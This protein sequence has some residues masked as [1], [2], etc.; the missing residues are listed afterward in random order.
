MNADSIKSEAIEW[1]KSIAIAVVLAFLLKTFVFNSTKVVGTSMFP[2]LSENDRVFVNKIVYDISEPQ[3]GDIITLEAPDREDAEYI[4]RI[5]GLAG[6]T[7]EIKE[8]KVYVNGEQLVE[9]YIAEGAYTDAYDT[10]KWEIPEGYV[11]VMGD[12][13]AFRASKDSR[14]LGLIEVDSIVGKASIRYFPLDKIDKF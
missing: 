3:R 10:S 12:N 1:A 4:K 6:D 11:F 5:I 8:G 13:R 14:S 7:V 9:D 2:T